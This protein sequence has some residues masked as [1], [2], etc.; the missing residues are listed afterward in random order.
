MF[1]LFV[2]YGDVGFFL[3]GA[4]CYVSEVKKETKAE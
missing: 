3:K 1:L 2:V 4:S